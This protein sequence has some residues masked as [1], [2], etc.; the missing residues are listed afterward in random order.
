MYVCIYIY[1]HIHI[2][3]Y[4]YICMYVCICIYIYIYIYIYI[5]SSFICYVLIH[6]CI[7]AEGAPGGGAVYVAGHSTG[8]RVTEFREPGLLSFLLLRDSSEGFAEIC[9]D[10]DESAQ[11]VCRQMSESWLV[12]FPRLHPRA[13]RGPAAA[14]VRRPPYIYIYIY[15]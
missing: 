14:R 5:T 13:P 7:Y 11:K 9:R 8:G 6:L 2:Y 10:D 15:V 4:I 12:K 3:I 1:I